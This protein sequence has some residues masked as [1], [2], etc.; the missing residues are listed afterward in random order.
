MLSR[1]EIAC[2]LNANLASN[3]GGR[4]YHI[5]SSN[6]AIFFQL[7]REETKQVI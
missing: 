4:C 7:I 2:C 6:P 5:L 3:A 1:V